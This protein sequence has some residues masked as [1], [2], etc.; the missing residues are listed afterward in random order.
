MKRLDIVQFAI[1]VVGIVSAALFLQNLPGI[2]YYISTWLVNGLRGGPFIESF[3]SS[4]LYMAIYLL[5]AIYAVKNSKQIAEWICNKSN[6]EGEV[7]FNLQKSELLFIVLI[8][9][10]IYGLIRTIPSLFL[11]FY[12]MTKEKQEFD[13]SQRYIMPFE[14]DGLFENVCFV[15]LNIIILV[16]ANVFAEFLSK[17][18]NNIEPPDAINLKDDE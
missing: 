8:A 16:Y 9:M 4:I 6:F 1:I 2:I 3:I 7:N 5:I 10:A 14:R 17:K 12:N 13:P 15:A 18:I 11:N